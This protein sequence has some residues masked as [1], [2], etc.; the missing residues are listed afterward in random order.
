MLSSEIRTRS[1][2]VLGKSIKI[3]P[4]LDSNKLYLGENHL[5]I[6]RN[7]QKVMVFIR[8]F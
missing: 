2:L 3:E 7:A 6:V 4:L 8:T 5:S 1:R